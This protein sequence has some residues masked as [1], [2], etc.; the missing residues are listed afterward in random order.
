MS[1]ESRDP[2]SPE[3]AVSAALGRYEWRAFTPELVVRHLLGALDHLAVLEVI[4]ATGTGDDLPVHHP[5]DRTDDRVEPLVHLLAGFRW[6]D[7]T[8]SRLVHLLLDG[9]AQWW[10]RRETFEHE[11]ARLLNDE[12]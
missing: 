2:T 9:L 4:G 5:V 12:R 8:L 3:R 10:T 6:R 7:L 11:L 1:G